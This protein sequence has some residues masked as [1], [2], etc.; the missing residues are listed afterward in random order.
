MTGLPFAKDSSCRARALD[1]G[2]DDFPWDNFDSRSYYEHNYATLRSDDRWIIEK[3]G[4]FFA[5]S[6]RRLAGTRNG[7]DVGS[8]TNLYP[9]MS[10][11]PW[12]ESVTLFERAS[13]NIDWLNREISGYSEAWDPFW[14]TLVESGGSV[15]SAIEP[16]RRVAECA[17]VEK[18]NVFHLPSAQ[19]DIGTMFFVA[20]SITCRRSEFKRAVALFVGSLRR[21]APFVIAFMKGSMGYPVGGQKFPA[22]RVDESDISRTLRNLAHDVEIAP[23]GKGV[24]P[25]R[26]GYD[27]MILAMG[28]AGRR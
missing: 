26:H 21:F 15:Y 1:G 3:M 7:V 8:G 12:C 9:M 2:N 24:E 19:W 25:L 23:I 20:E 28:R 14:E 27:G 22:V 4:R 16:R 11:L 5:N 18:G 10:M 17:H 13:S 6:D